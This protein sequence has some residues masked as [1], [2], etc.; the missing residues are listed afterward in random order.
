[1]EEERK[2]EIIIISAWLYFN[3]LYFN[4][5]LSSLWTQLGP[6][7]DQQVF[8]FNQSNKPKK[9]EADMNEMKVPEVLSVKFSTEYGIITLTD[10]GGKIFISSFA[11]ATDG[12]IPMRLETELRRRFAILKAVNNK[13]PVKEPDRQPRLFPVPGKD[14]PGEE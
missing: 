8:Y 12:I 1:M 11:P 13:T 5:H 2:S 6:S 14:F 3:L 7:E 4:A 10:R 9:E